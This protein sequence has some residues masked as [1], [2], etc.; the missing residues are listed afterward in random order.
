MSKY[1]FR[2]S[3]QYN[4]NTLFVQTLA[5]FKI[6]RSLKFAQGWIC[7]VFLEKIW[8]CEIFDFVQTRGVFSN[9]NFLKE[10]PSCRDQEMLWQWNKWE[11]ISY[12][13]H[14]VVGPQDYWNSLFTDN[15]RLMHSVV[16]NFA[17]GRKQTSGD[18][19]TENCWKTAIFNF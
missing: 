5:S 18:C 9:F 3:Y 12:Q 19:K 7:H 13:F 1:S 16:T 8:N 4:V 10:K 15:E 2:R 11:V 17:V 6:G 14:D